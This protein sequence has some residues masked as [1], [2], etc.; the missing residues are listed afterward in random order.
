MPLQE[1]AWKVRSRLSDEGLVPNPSNLV[2][3]GSE[4]RHPQRGGEIGISFLPRHL[5]KY[6]KRYSVVA[7]YIQL[8]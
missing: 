4:A 1:V 6:G 7:R 8:S 2:L 3:A 5:S